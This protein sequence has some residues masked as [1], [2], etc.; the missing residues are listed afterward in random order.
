MPTP[1]DYAPQP[2]KADPYQ[3]TLLGR[4]D[5]KFLA[6]PH[7]R[8][9][10]AMGLLAA[11]IVPTVQ[12]CKRIQEIDTSLFRTEGSRHRTALGRWL[13]TLELV[14][15]GKD[16]SNPYGYGHWF[17]T[18]PP[19]LLAAAPLAKLGYFGAGVAWSIAK[20]VGF[21][22]AMAYFV[23]GLR[24][25]GRAVPIGVLLVA[26]AFSI[27]PI[28]S[29]IQHGNL[30]L[31]MLIW[32]ALAWG[33]FVRGRDMA[34]GVFVALAIVTKVTPGL[35]LVYF[36]YKRQW[37][38]VAATLVA[39]AVLLLLLPG[40]A[41][42]FDT[43]MQWLRT[44]FDMLARPYALEGFATIEI[45]NQSLYGTLLRILGNAGILSIEHMP[46]QRAL[47]AGMEDMARPA[48]AIGRLLRPVISFSILLALAWLCRAKQVAASGCI[49]LP[50]PA[51]G[52]A[53]GEGGSSHSSS[54]TRGR[55]NP[56]LWLEFA[57]VLVAMLLM[58]ERTWKH[59][60]TTLPLVFIAV[61]YVLVTIDW[62]DRFRAW[63][64]GGLVVQLFLLV[65]GSEGLIGDD[66]AERLLDGGLFCWGLVLCGV[67]TGILLHKFRQRS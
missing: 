1:A 11:L 18:P 19:V 16:A 40:L 41:V 21:F 47:Q 43:N 34:A 58:S 2:S 12:F 54:P 4:F 6:L 27:R 56:A 32:L 38:V 20:L 22:G 39:L 13:P 9:A 36:L 45:A 59:H 62:T 57:V 48:T 17:P 46:T 7:V 42:G 35:L 23:S 25:T 29:D 52:A 64:V 26:A 65:V 33:C 24:T 53:W 66:A 51:K 55:S 14:F 67:Q 15:E 28:I 31:F 44:W 3:K 5:Q 30:N 10:L 8:I 50:S 60:A 61:W 63:F 37:R 49:E